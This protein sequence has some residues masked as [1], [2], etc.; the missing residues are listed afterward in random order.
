MVYHV[1]AT[2]GLARAGPASLF[3]RQGVRLCGGQLLVTGLL[4]GARHDDFDFLIDV[5]AR[6]APEVWECYPGAFDAV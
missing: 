5:D 3:S 4:F 1:S 2:P 6:G